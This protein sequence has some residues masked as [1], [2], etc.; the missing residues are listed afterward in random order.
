MLA[1]RVV[2]AVVFATSAAGKLADLRGSR[3]SLAGFGV[4]QRT[5]T[6]LGTLLP[7]AELA[8][9]IALIHRPSAQWGGVGALALLVAF[10]GGIARALR[11]GEAPPCNCFGAIHSAP[12]SRTT[13]VRNVGLAAV[14]VVAVGW[15]P[16]PA[17]DT[18]VSARSVAELTTVGLGITAL[19]LLAVG[20][21]VW[22]DNRRLRGDIAAAEDR[23][24]RIPPGLRVGSLAPEFSLPDGTGGRL[25]LTSLLAPGRPVVLVFTVAGCGPCETLVPDLRR[26]QMIAAERVTIALVGIHTL[27]RYDRVRERHAGELLLIDAVKEDPRLQEEL[28]ELIEVSHAYDVHHSPGA[29][30]VTPAGTIGSALVDGR[31]AIEALIRLTISGALGPVPRYGAS[32]PQPTARP[33]PVVQPRD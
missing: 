14:A 27:E 29:V 17:I 24:R 18:W 13:L 6:V 19:V 15:G 20:A 30:L 3:A 2:L 28:D 23:V 9:A 10:I 21:P 11:R 32:R 26:L 1:A 12:A 16:G 33:E 5:A 25:T 7:F 4:P 31:P 8:V 22:L